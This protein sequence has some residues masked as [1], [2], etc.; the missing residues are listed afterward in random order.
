MSSVVGGRIRGGIRR[1]RAEIER[2]GDFLPPHTPPAAQESKAAVSALTTE[3]PQSGF[4][5]IPKQGAPF[6]KERPSFVYGSADFDGKLPRDCSIASNQFISHGFSPALLVRT[7]RIGE[8]KP[9][10]YILFAPF[11]HQL[12]QRLQRAPLWR[13]GILHPRGHLGV[14]RA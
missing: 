12:Q 13:D 2:A 8:F 1:L 11:A 6:C 14:H 4:F 10:I 9:L 3:I 7:L 5:R